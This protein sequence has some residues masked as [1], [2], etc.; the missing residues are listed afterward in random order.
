MRWCNG[1]TCSRLKRPSFGF[2]GKIYKKG[3]KF[4]KMCGTFMVVNSN[5]CPCCSSS[6]RTKSHASK[7]RRNHLRWVV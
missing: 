3:V 4:C 2:G 6:L 5:H 7:L 1:V